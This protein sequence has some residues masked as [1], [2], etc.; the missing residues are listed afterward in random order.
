MTA[1]QRVGRTRAYLATA[2]AIAAA[3]WA[4]AAALA[5]GVA[6]VLIARV[7]G[8]ALPDVVS[9]LPAAAALLAAGTV[10]YRAWPGRSLERVALW[11]EEQE[12]SL[13][14]ALVTASDPA[15]PKSTALE[16]AAE[17]DPAKVMRRPLASML[18]GAAA[19]VMISGAA[20]WA[21]TGPDATRDMLAGRTSTAP[22]RSAAASEDPLAG[23]RATVTPPAYA[24]IRAS[25]VDDPSG[26]AALRGSR[27][28]VTGRGS[29]VAAFLGD[30]AV[31]VGGGRRWT[32]AFTMPARPVALTLRHGER[33]RVIVLEPRTD[34]PPRVRLASPA[35]DTI[36]QRAGGVVRVAASIEE[37]VGIA[38]GHIEYMLSSGAEE[39]FTARTVVVG[40]REFGG[41]VRGDLSATIDLGALNLGPGDL[42]S[43]RA[44]ARD[45]NIVSGPGIG[46]S[47]T[48]TYRVARRDE[49]DSLAIE[50][51]APIVP[52]STVVSQRMLILRTEALLRDQPALSRDSVLSRVRGIATDQIRLRERVHDII[53]PAHTHAE[54]EVE[55]EGEPEDAEESMGPVNPHLK[56]AYEEMWSASR[57]LQIAE[58]TAA[59]PFMRAAAAALDR[60]R[61]ANRYY[62]RSGA[63]RVVVDV[64]RVRLQG[65]E[66]GTSAARSP[67]AAET[68]RQEIAR[69][70][71]RAA[72]IRDPVSAANELALV[73]VRALAELPE[74]A[75]A[76]EPVIDALR[77]G[78]NP[79]AALAA[80]RSELDR[81]DAAARDGASWSRW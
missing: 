32:V 68:A 33:R 67:R 26:I 46:V 43:I 37:D 20:A 72:A 53:Y 15:L 49:Y 17:F 62:L 2:V 28:T 23:I 81:A 66:T 41:A 65:K 55:A 10:A 77:R 38:G 47:D 4:V 79:R 1:R 7:T 58:A 40:R 35:R 57:E 14:F 30:A 71:T 69:H 61:L 29:G 63:A 13:A 54:G 70:F 60:A 80:A 56:T 75:E 39:T 36:M 27:I 12:P 21:L 24:R 44:V 76:L 34:A 18:L 52:E 22:L 11:V 64:P 78:R 9:L 16:R 73:R 25:S 3:A 45:A 48:R 8:S 50:A 42:L 51:G 31:R 74:L 59:L 5:T 19:A 6:L